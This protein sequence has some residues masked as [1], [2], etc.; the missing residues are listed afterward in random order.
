M[1]VTVPKRLVAVVR[2]IIIIISHYGSSRVPSVQAGGKIKE[3][4]NRQLKR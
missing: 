4:L 1:E 2:F 3:E